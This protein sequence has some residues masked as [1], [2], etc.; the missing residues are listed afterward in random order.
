V[1]GTRQARDPRNREGE[2]ELMA[3]VDQGDTT[4]MEGAEME[5]EN[6]VPMS[7]TTAEIEMGGGTSKD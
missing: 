6:D 4:E 1:L 3:N 7:E 2:G 5:M